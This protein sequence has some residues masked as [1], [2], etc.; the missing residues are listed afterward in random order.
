[1]QTQLYD[2]VS[3]CM[4]YMYRQANKVSSELKFLCALDY[5]SSL[6]KYYYDY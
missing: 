3:V 4:G 5:G 6:N 1:M 2:T